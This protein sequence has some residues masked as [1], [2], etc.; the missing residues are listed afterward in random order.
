MTECY[1]YLI[2]T[3]PGNKK[4]GI[5]SKPNQRL[6]QIQ[7]GNPE[8]LEIFFTHRVSSKEL[9]KSIESAAHRD[10]AKFRLKGEWFD[11][12]I[13]I[14]KKAIIEAADPSIKKA[15]TEA[16]RIARI[17]ELRT[18]LQRN[19]E[20]NKVI[21]TEMKRLRDSLDELSNLL[22]DNLREWGD[23]TDELRRLE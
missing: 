1:V 5:A 9:A 23:V 3:E 2:G 11:V 6:R 8:K 20:E 15:H 18:I 12:S 21:T 17:Q 10:L 13:D 19:Q 14:G 16:E 4:I 22:M 7:T